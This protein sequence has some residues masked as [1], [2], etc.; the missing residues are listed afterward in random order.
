VSDPTIR[1]V[2]LA[3]GAAREHGPLLD[4]LAAEGVGAE[5]IL[6]VHNPSEPGQQPPPAAGCEV[7]ANE[8]NLG[9]AAAMNRGIERQLER[10]CELLLLATHDARLREGALRAMTDAAAR[11]PD[12]GALGPALVFAGT[13][14]PFSFGGTTG[15]GG[16]VGHRASAPPLRDGIAPCEWIDGGTML[17]RAAALERTG[18]FDERFWGYYEDADLCLRLRRAGYGVGVVAAARADQAPG[19]SKRPGAWSYLLTRNG[20][21]YARRFAG[22]RG[23]AAASARAAWGVLL[24]LARTAARLTP[25]RPGRPA[26]RWAVAVGTARGAVDFYAG[27]WGPP[28]PSLPGMGDLRNAEATAST[29]AVDG[30]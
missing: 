27:R 3:Y 21:A 10:G 4:S 1:V 6:L 28:P 5:R 19:G 7:L 29:G 20:I 11:H 14:T 12:Y 2:V 13:E 30:G 23:A 26:E 9:Y 18:G 8:R 24:E 25:L 15:P 17:L 22:A 16:G